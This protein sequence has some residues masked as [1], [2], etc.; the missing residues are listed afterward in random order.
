MIVLYFL[1]NY[2][3]LLVSILSYNVI[4]MYIYEEYISKRKGIIKERKMIQDIILEYI[5]EIV[6]VCLF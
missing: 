6:F 4:Y 3:Y 1:L 5:K 2:K